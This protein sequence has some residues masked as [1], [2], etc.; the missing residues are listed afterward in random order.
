MIALVIA[1]AV[2]ILVVMLTENDSDTVVPGP[3]TDLTRN[4]KLTNST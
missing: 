2:A 1:I 4:I 3:P